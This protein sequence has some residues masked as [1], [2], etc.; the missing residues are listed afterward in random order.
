[1]LD[2][3]I[4]THVKL[5]YP[6]GSGPF[7]HYKVAAQIPGDAPRGGA[8]G[9]PAEAGP[10]SLPPLPASCW[11]AKFRL[12]C[13]LS[14]SRADS[15]DRSL[16]LFSPFF[17]PPLSF[18]CEP[19]PDEGRGP[20][21]PSGTC[22]FALPPTSAT[23]GIVACWIAPGRL[24][25]RKEGNPP[26]LTLPSHSKNGHVARNHL[27]K[28]ATWSKHD[29]P[30]K[31]ASFLEASSLPQPCPP[32][33]HSSK[34]AENTSLRRKSRRPAPNAEC[35][36]RRCTSSMH[37]ACAH[38][39]GSRIRRQARWPRD[40]EPR[41]NH[42]FQKSCSGNLKPAL[43]SKLRFYWIQNSPLYFILEDIEQILFR[44]KSFHVYSLS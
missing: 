40:L 23:G 43:I 3:R 20:I 19:L 16:D 42:Q 24:R 34:G 38:L 27:R 1:M 7:S 5:R 13:S 36:Q 17:P 25:Q 4:N 9:L 26:P 44:T 28:T 33:G 30:H 21:E 15:A 39:H 8:V 35:M 18:P 14:R 12:T 10:L 6:K 2:T 41:H 37:H 32:V 31:L 29:T 22:L 11:S